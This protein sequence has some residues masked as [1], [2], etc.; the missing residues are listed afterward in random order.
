[1]KKLIILLLLPI[2][3]LASNIDRVTIQGKFRYNR[4]V[5]RYINSL[6][7]RK[8]TTVTHLAYTL[9]QEGRNK[10]SGDIEYH[11]NLIA[12][13]VVNR[14]R[15]NRK[16]WGKTIYR[17]IHKP[18]QFSCW[19]GMRQCKPVSS[20]Y[21]EFILALKVAVEYVHYHKEPITTATY[22]HERTLHPRWRL[23]LTKVVSFGNHIFYKT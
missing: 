17:V 3:A 1:M 5:V 16:E 11:Y 15:A 10:S 14:A 23:K 4:E 21:K 13:V 20:D 6:P 22:Y 9:W 2:V 19:S 7:K 18:H 8:L 12:S